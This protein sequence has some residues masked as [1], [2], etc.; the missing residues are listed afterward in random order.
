MIG[1]TYG[2]SGFPIWPLPSENT[3]ECECGARITMRLFVGER[4]TCVCGTKYYSDGAG[5]IWYWPPTEGGVE[6]GWRG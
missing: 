2:D 1:A 3:F 6:P 5:R 4:H